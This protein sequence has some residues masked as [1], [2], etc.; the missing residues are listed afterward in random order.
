MHGLLSMERTRGSD[1]FVVELISAHIR[2]TAGS[3]GE[4]VMNDGI[5]MTKGRMACFDIMIPVRWLLPQL[6][7]VKPPGLFKAL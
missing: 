4:E 3:W 5:R 1:V 6:M 7:C 2:D